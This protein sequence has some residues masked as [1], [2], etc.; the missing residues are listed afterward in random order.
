MFN[1]LDETSF[2]SPPVPL[3]R[4]TFALPAELAW[5]GTLLGPLLRPLHVRLCHSHVFSSRSDRYSV[6]S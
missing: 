5:E 1:A 4:S 3:I 6:H 2:Q